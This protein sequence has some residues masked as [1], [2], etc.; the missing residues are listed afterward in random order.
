MHPWPPGPLLDPGSSNQGR[1]HETPFFGKEENSETASRT[2]RSL[3]HRAPTYKVWIS[4][5]WES[6]VRR[7]ELS[8]LILNPAAIRL[9]RFRGHKIFP[10][11]N[12]ITCSGWV[13]GTSHWT[14][15]RGKYSD[16]KWD[17]SFPALCFRRHVSGAMFPAP[18]PSGSGKPH[19][20]TI[21]IVP[22]DGAGGVG[23]NKK[24]DF[25]VECLL[26]FFLLRPIRWE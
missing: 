16:L 12:R 20:S 9:F 26:D 15:R 2:E 4:R 19:S 22:I 3:A 18:F 1:H 13:P 8:N 10:L 6:R 25:S 21:S 14:R 23:G 5:E 11:K 7:S 24:E 17:S